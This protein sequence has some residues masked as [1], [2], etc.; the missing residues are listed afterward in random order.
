MDDSFWKEGT[1]WKTSNIT[2]VLPLRKFEVMES[3]FF[4]TVFASRNNLF[5]QAWYYQGLTTFASNSDIPQSFAF[6]GAIREK[7]FRLTSKK[8]KTID[9]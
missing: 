4:S 8:N 1:S 3:S 5:C 7:W 6:Y 2:L 9:F